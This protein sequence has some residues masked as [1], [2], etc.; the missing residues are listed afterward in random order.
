MESGFNFKKEYPRLDK[1]IH[2][3][4]PSIVFLIVFAIVFFVLQRIALITGAISNMS[5]AESAVLSFP[6]LNYID[7]M[8]IPSAVIALVVIYI[9]RRKTHVHSIRFTKRDGDNV[10]FYDQPGYDDDRVKHEIGDDETLR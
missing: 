7:P 6:V 10:P 8:L 3:I 1:F 4:S 9:H 2:F 5:L